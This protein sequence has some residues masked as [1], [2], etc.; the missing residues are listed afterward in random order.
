MTLIGLWHGI[1]W[2]FVLWGVWHGLGLFVQNRF[3]DWMKPRQA[4]FKERPRLERGMNVLN[5]VLTFHFVA[6]GWVW[7]ALPQVSLSW[8]VLLTCFGMAG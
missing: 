5:T 7:F 3:S 6:L 1:T 8:H 4:I 2:N